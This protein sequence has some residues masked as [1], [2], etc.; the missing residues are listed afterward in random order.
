MRP[1]RFVSKPPPNDPIADFMEPD[2]VNKPHTGNLLVPFFIALK[3]TTGIDKRKFPTIFFM[4]VD[5]TDIFSVIT[6]T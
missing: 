6:H 5:W 4:L 3:K 2:K 1:L